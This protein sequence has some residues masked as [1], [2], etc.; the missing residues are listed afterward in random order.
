MSKTDK[1]EYLCAFK[2][3]MAGQLTERHGHYFEAI[4]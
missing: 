2:Q 4:F 3:N 1:G